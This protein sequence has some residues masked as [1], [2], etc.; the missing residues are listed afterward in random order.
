MS[1]YVIHHHTKMMLFRWVNA[2]WSPLFDQT[3]SGFAD[4]T[5]MINYVNDYW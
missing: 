3:E 2:K 4:K 5:H 1:D